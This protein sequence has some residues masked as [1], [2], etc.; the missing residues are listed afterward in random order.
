MKKYLLL[1]HC[2]SYAQEIGSS[3]KLNH[4]VLSVEENLYDNVI[5]F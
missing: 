4:L 3:E 5:P 2:I 1:L